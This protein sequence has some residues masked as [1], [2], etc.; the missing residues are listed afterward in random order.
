MD[1]VGPQLVASSSS[2]RPLSCS[3]ILILRA[4]EN[5]SYNSVIFSS[6]A[7]NNYAVFV[8]DSA[9]V[10]ATSVDDVKNIPEPI[11]YVA[12]DLREAARNRSLQRL[13]NSACIQAYA[14][15]YL[16]DRSNL[17]LVASDANST[18][19]PAVFSIA[20]I[21]NVEL[22]N[23]R[24]CAPDLYAWICADARCFSPCQSHLSEVLADAEHWR[25]NHLEDEI[26][27]EAKYCLSQ[28]TPEHCKLQFSLQIVIV[29]IV[30]NTLKMV[31]M[32][33]VVFGLKETPL[34]TIGDAVASFLN[35]ED[36]TT[37]GCCL[38]SKFDIKINKL[39]WQH[40]DGESNAPVAKEWMPTKVRWARAVSRTRW[41]ACG[42]M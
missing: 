37:K 23:S 9:F 39:R 35:E 42:V 3:Q 30:I 27:S 28:Q 13:D 5:C 40:R 1:C 6:I 12:M 38:V 31:L 25:P 2:V 19:T 17:L 32:L 18:S 24:N 14:H 29:V 22:T 15:D 33:Y 34:M 16:S 36:P 8:V 7:T 11:K 10:D 26:A 41:W 20:T 21:N 4:N